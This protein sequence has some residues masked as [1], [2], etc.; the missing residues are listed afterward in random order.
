MES[1]LSGLTID[2]TDSCYI[3]PLITVDN[4]ENILIS[5]F[6]STSPKHNGVASGGVI[7]GWLFQESVT[8]DDIMVVA[9]VHIPSERTVLQ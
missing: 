2:S 6:G 9:L 4:L 3:V 8:P 7:I 1:L 5:T